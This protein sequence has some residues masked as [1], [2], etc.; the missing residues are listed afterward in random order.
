MAASTLSSALLWRLPVLLVL[1]GGLLARALRGPAQYRVV[2]Q[3]RA[4]AAA[5]GQEAADD[6]ADH[7]NDDD[8]GL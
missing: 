6:G 7:E 5:Q 4:A 2:R 3:S 8:D 1:R